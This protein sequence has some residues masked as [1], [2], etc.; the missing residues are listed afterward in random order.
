M[1][2]ADHPTV[3]GL[4]EILHSRI[5]SVMQEFVMQ[6]FP[7]LGSQSMADRIFEQLPVRNL[8]SC[9]SIAI[10]YTFRFRICQGHRWLSIVLLFLGLVP[11]F[12]FYHLGHFSFFD[13]IY[14][15]FRVPGS[16]WSQLVRQD[17]YH[18]CIDRPV[19]IN[20]ECEEWRR[21]R[22][23]SSH[24]QGNC[25]DQLHPSTRNWTPASATACHFWGS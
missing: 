22:R 5:R 1:E 21:S 9:Q 11:W 12:H 4:E 13:L 17:W 24:L 7:V 18:N 19:D 20:L 10:K 25:K 15:S 3:Q 14:Q 16:M 2:Y 23:T 6:P 8:I